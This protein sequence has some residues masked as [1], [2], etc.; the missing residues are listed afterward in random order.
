MSVFSIAAGGPESI[1]GAD[2]N[3]PQLT[4]RLLQEHRCQCCRLAHLCRLCQAR[5]ALSAF[6]PAWLWLGQ[7]YLI[8]LLW[9]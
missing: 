1:C 9:P 6:S 5:P 8:E 2:S 4:S 3:G 7:T